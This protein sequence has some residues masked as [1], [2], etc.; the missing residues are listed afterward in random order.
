MRRS[1]R[2][3]PAPVSSR[4][5][6]LPA[7]HGCLSVGRYARKSNGA[8]RGFNDAPVVPSLTDPARAAEQTWTPDSRPRFTLTLLDPP[9]RPF[10]VGPCRAL[11]WEGRMMQ[12]AATSHRPNA[13]QRHT[14]S[15]SR[16]TR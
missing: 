4:S 14:A 3:A 5:V 12:D 13:D 6:P 15:V 16:I 7:I 2:R 9:V 8:P 10:S 1:S 11:A